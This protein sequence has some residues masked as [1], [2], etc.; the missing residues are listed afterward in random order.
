MLCFKEDSYIIDK[1]DPYWIITLS[2]GRQVY[3]DDD[4]PGEEISSAWLRLREYLID[5]PQVDI[6]EM[7]VK[8]RSNRIR[9]EL[10]GDGL[11]LCKGI[12]AQIGVQTTV[13]TQRPNRHYLIFGNVVDGKA[14][15]KKCN[16]PELNITDE[17]E[18]REI[19]E[20][21]ECVIWYKKKKNG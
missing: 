18:V 20:D 19:E 13:A 14:H 12:I 8:F 21:S 9:I 1:D 4:R 3:Q 7:V 11:Y 5:N 2:E 16:L 6:E 17:H 10:S 15:V